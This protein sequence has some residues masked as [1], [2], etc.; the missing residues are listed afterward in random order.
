MSEDP[1]ERVRRQIH[2]VDARS[3]EQA[4]VFRTWGR[5]R[6]LVRIGLGRL[7]P[8]FA[9]FVLLAGVWLFPNWDPPLLRE[10]FP[11][12]VR[13]VGVLLVI[14]CS[15]GLLAAHRAWSAYKRTWFTILDNEPR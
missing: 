4:R 9:V 8:L 5:T 14:S 10:I 6:Y 3:L 15:L 7:A 1:I 13:W 2:E 11:L 12:R